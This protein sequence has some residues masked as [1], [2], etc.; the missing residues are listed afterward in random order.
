MLRALSHTVSQV[1]IRGQLLQRRYK[2]NYLE[3]VA[4]AILSI[5]HR[6]EYKELCDSTEGKIM[7]PLIVQT[8]HIIYQVINNQ[9]PIF[10]HH[11]GFHVITSGFIVY[12][13]MGLLGGPITSGDKRKI[14]YG[15]GIGTFNSAIIFLI[16]YL[17]WSGCM[18]LKREFV[19][20]FDN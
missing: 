18:K 7:F 13:L 10:D 2:A 3:F 16:L 8:N 19:S 12:G 4:G 20:R 1:P 9:L 6:D 15:S 14:L 5:F 17:V 11:I